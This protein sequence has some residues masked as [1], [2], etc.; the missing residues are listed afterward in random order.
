[1]RDCNRT[2]IY[3]PFIVSRNTDI[4][5]NQIAKLSISSEMLKDPRMIL[6]RFSMGRPLWCSLAISEVIRIAAI[7]LAN[8]SL[9][10]GQAFVACWMLRTGIPASPHMV[11]TSRHLLKSNMATL[12]DIHPELPLMNVCYP[13][14]PVLAMA[15][16]DLVSRNLIAYFKNLRNHLVC[17]GFDRVILPKL[18]RQ[19]FVLRRLQMPSG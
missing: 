11:E 8:S 4:F 15:A 6:I 14:E 3:P 18:L 13:S 17:K 1:M 19:K 7:K 2:E 12:L 5:R 10:S 9:E 16:D